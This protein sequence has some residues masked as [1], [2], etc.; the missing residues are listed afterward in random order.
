MVTINDLKRFKPNFNFFIGLDS[1]GTIFDSMNL[2]HN[3]CFIDPLVKIY[4]LS[5]IKN[6]VKKIWKKIN[7]FSENEV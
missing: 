6:D 1:D 5:G 7:L 4:K 3:Y 2:K